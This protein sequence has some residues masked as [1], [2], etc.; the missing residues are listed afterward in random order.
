MIKNKVSLSNIK[1]EIKKFYDYKIWHFFNYLLIEMEK[2]ACA[3]MC[4]K[5]TLGVMF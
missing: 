1:E 2:L 3:E 5:L 4:R